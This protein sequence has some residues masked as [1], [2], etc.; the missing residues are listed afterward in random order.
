ML[1]NVA[2][3]TAG[4]GITCNAIC[5]GYVDT[6]RESSARLIVKMYVI[7]CEG[8]IVQRECCVCLAVYQAQVK[9]LAERDKLSYDDAQRK[10]LSTVQPSG[11][12]VPVDDVRFMQCS[13]KLSDCL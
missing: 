12:S 9:V 6:P 10:F 11:K 2:L 1:Q 8:G 7:D 13:L 4:Q 5:P 3:E